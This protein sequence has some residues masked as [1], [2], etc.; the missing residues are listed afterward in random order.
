MHAHPAGD[1]ERRRPA[2]RKVLRQVELH[3]GVRHTGVRLRGGVAGKHG[4][5]S[6]VHPNGVQSGVES[7]SWGEHGR[8]VCGVP[9][10]R[11]RGHLARQLGRQRERVVVERG[12]PRAGHQ[13]D[14]VHGLHVRQRPHVLGAVQ[15]VGQDVGAGRQTRRCSARGVCGVGGDAREDG[16]RSP[17]PTG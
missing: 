12:V 11:I 2:T 9:W 1:Q 17:G 4:G 6:A 15:R 16:E 8:D 10:R 5:A 7:E 3:E 13:V 14:H